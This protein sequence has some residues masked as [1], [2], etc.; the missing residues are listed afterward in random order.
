MIFKNYTIGT[1][2]NVPIKTNVFTFVYL[3]I[4][5]YIFMSESYFYTLSTL[6][7]SYFGIVLG[8]EIAHVLV[9]RHY[10][11][12]TN[13]ILINV[14]GGL[15]VIPRGDEMS[16]KETLFV[17]IAGPL[18]NVLLIP[19]LFILDNEFLNA[20]NLLMIIFNLI[21]FYPLD[22]GR[23]MRASIG[24]FVKNN[25]TLQYITFY[26]A[27]VCFCGLMFAAFY[28]RNII[29]CI[30]NLW[31]IAYNYIQLHRV[32]NQEILDKKPKNF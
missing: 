16:H 28:F 26:V 17:S 18:F 23:I 4:L 29:L 19:F 21:P 14:F 10:G 6:L 32:I 22:G 15:A 2:F 12:Q 25:T 20:I 11:Y 8:H 3:M 27:C 13:E 30:L 7:V 31:L 1:I 9:A 24:F 5:S